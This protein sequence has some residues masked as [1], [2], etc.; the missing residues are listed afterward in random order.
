MFNAL[1]LEKPQK[2]GQLG[3]LLCPAEPALFH[4]TLRLLGRCR[5]LF[6]PASPSHFKTEQEV[7]A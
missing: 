2:A 5:V 1:S 7:V 6:S 3:R 4:A